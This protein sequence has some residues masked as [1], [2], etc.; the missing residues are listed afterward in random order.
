MVPLPPWLPT[1]SPQPRQTPAP[2]D[3]VPE[4]T[5]LPLRTV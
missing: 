5:D 2:T 4:P 3:V 1:P